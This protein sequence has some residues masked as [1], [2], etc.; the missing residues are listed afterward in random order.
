MEKAIA[1]H[2]HMS[3]QF[4]REEL[5]RQLQSVDN[6]MAYAKL[7]AYAHSS[8]AMTLLNDLLSFLNQKCPDCQG[9]TEHPC[10]RTEF[11]EE[12]EERLA[13][14]LEATLQAHHSKL[15]VVR[16]SDFH[17]SSQQEVPDKHP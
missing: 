7:H 4:F 16:P 5:L 13:I 12:A 8:L 15:I 3:Y 9:T 2:V 11:K 10:I 1:D 17:D 6:N 14:V